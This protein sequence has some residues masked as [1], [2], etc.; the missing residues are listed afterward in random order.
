MGVTLTT[1][2]QGVGRLLSHRTAYETAN[3]SG[4]T[5]TNIRSNN[6]RSYPNGYFTGHWVLITSG[7]DSGNVVYCTNH[8]NT[9]GDLTVTPAASG[10][11]VYNSATFEIYPCQPAILTEA[12][13]KAV[14]L[15]SSLI[16]RSVVDESFVTGSPIRNG[17]LQDW[18]STTTL[19]FWTATTMT[20]AKTAS[21]WG[22]NS[23]DAVVTGVGTLTTATGLARGEFGALHGYSPTLYAFV[24]GGSDIACRI[25]DADGSTTGTSNSITG[26]QLIQATRSIRSATPY[27]GNSIAF[28]IVVTTNAT[29]AQLLK[30]WVEGGPPLNRYFSPSYL[31]NGPSAVYIARITDR[32]HY[33]F[34]PWSSVSF[35]TERHEDTNT[36]TGAN[37]TEVLLSPRIPP[38]M[39]MKWVGR[40]ALTELAVSADV[41]EIDTASAELVETEAAI[42]ALDMNVGMQI[43][44]KHDDVRAIQ[45]RL[46]A[47]RAWLMAKV[48]DRSAPASLPSDL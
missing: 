42:Q 35:T 34:G 12:I 23:Y 28:T 8:A 41:L 19:A 24:G 29:T 4:N 21:T 20:L 31:P 45:Q 30:V 13:N 18:D 38:G 36:N 1:L 5:T 48:H 16:E 26:A 37:R 11:G 7:T 2:R 15:L 25:T 32:Q 46:E 3:S 39:A 22:P 17:G 9:N 10:A 14:R 43:V 27:T 33:R 47:R 6:L 44:T 40:G